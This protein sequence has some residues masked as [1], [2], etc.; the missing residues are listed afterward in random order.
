MVI[1]EMILKSLFYILVLIPLAYQSLFS[2]IIA[3]FMNV[4]VILILRL[5]KKNLYVFS[6]Y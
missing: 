4:F 6:E 3:L 2:K 5:A 1:K